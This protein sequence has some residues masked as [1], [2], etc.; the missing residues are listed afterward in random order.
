MQ[1]SFDYL[2]KHDVSVR[3][4]CETDKEILFHWR[5]NPDVKQFVRS[6]ATITT[7]MHNQ[8]FEKR[9]TVRDR[10]P[11]FIFS[12]GNVPLGMTRLDL[13]EIQPKCYEI[14]ILVDERFHNSGHG[15]RMLQYTCEAAVR[16]YSA[17]IIQ[18]IIHKENVASLN[19]F[20]KMHFSKKSDI[21]ANFSIFELNY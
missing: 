18:A 12:L 2:A 4:V 1:G 16:Q 15:R 19:L 17:S 14:S 20:L 11:I 21:D 6:K 3:L 9:M 13:L 5:N 8:W 10:E 7:E